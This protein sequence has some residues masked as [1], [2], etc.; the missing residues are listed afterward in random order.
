MEAHKKRKGKAKALLMKH[1]Q[2]MHKC[3]GYTTLAISVAMLGLIL[4]SI[5]LIVQVEYC[6]YPRHSKSE[7]FRYEIK[8]D[9]TS[10]KKIARDG[11]IKKYVGPKIDHLKIEQFFG[12][13]TFVENSDLTAN[14]VVFRVNNRAANKYFLT[15]IASLSVE[16]GQAPLLVGKKDSEL[17]ANVTLT[18]STS[19]SLTGEFNCRRADIEVEVPTACLLDETKLFTHVTKGHIQ[20]KNLSAA[21]FETIS[22]ANEV[23]D[24]RAN[25]LHAFKIEL[26][27]STGTIRSN[28]TACHTMRVNSDPDRDGALLYIHN[29][30]LFEGDNKTACVEELGYA[31]GFPHTPE[32]Q[33]KTLQCET[34]P[35]VLVIDS[36]G[37]ENAG[38]PAITLGRVKGG[39]VKQKIK[40]G[41]TRVQIMGCLDFIGDYILRTSAGSISISEK[42]NYY[43]D[44]GFSRVVL[45][46]L[47]PLISLNRTLSSSK[48]KVGTICKNQTSIDT[49]VDGSGENRITNQTLE[50]EAE[51]TGDIYFDIFPPHI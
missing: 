30:T 10:L 32:Y 50:I 39:N 8:F 13:V 26:N 31:P 12:T 18:A 38:K 25:D 23:G 28:N 41:H 24:I 4:A 16:L 6:R 44:T 40:V 33:I 34:E 3:I 15:R 51:V 17:R 36:K 19:N 7:E 45:N 21:N 11:K 2:R 20:S 48:T 46:N 14:E 35:G 47:V 5:I 27:T 9:A 1:K 43:R 29:V 37:A 42:T 49:S 22:L